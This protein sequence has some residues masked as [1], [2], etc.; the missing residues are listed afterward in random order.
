[1]DVL[2]LHVDQ[3]R[4]ALDEVAVNLGSVWLFLERIRQ[5]TNKV[6]CGHTMM[7]C[8]VGKFRMGRAYLQVEGLMIKLGGHVCPWKG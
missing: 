7:H 3:V 8:K 2:P 4:L 6:I 1:M 5:K